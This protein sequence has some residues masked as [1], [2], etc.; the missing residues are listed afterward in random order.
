MK[1]RIV[2]TALVAV[3]LIGCQGG[4]PEDLAEYVAAIRACG[5]S[6]SAQGD[7]RMIASIRAGTTILKFV[8]DEASGIYFQ[9]YTSS[10]CP[11]KNATP[12]EIAEFRRAREEQVN[13]ELELLKPI[14]DVD[15]SGFVSTEEGIQFRRMYEFGM[16]ANEVLSIEAGELAASARAL[17]FTVEELEEKVSEYAAFCA[18]LGADAER[19]IPPVPSV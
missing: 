5:I 6:E 13:P 12:E 10:E 1:R 11:K 9:Q 17:G 4:E 18:T 15:N 8:K 2:I 7:I 14:A 19:V 16:K 3:G